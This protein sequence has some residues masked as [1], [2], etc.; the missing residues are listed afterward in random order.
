MK[1]QNNLRYCWKS[2]VTENPYDPLRHLEIGYDKKILRGREIW[3]PMRLRSL[4]FGLAQPKKQERSNMSLPVNLKRF[5]D[6]LKSLVSFATCWDCFP[7]PVFKESIHIGK[8]GSIQ[9]LG[10]V[11][12]IFQFSTEIRSKWEKKQERSNM[13]LPVNLKRFSDTLKT[14]VSFL[15]PYWD[16]FQTPGRDNK[17]GSCDKWR[18]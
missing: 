7:P 4:A 17:G 15:P 3:Y 16:C 13:S 14:L 12:L 5:L 11:N 10:S 8:I 2:R 9:F 18:V 1:G 6:T